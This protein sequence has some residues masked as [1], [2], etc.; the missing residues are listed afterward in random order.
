MFAQLLFCIFLLDVCFWTLFV[1]TTWHSIIKTL[2]WKIFAQL[3]HIL[4]NLFIQLNLGGENDDD[5]LNS[6]CQRQICLPISPF[7]MV[8]WFRHIL[9]FMI[10]TFELYCLLS[11]WLVYPALLQKSFTPIL[12]YPQ[13]KV[14]RRRNVVIY[15]VTSYDLLLFYVH[16]PWIGPAPVHISAIR[17]PARCTH[18]FCY[19]LMDVVR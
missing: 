18:K 10:L 8:G 13:S 15:E 3:P 9:D 6:P 5:L 7:N 4:Y 11:G 14:I 17:K 16:H 19:T 12:S 1:I 2:P